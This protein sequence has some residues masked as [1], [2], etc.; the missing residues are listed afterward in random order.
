VRSVLGGIN[1]LKEDPGPLKAGVSSYIIST[2]EAD[3]NVIVK[4]MNVSVNCNCTAYLFC[5]LW[6]IGEKM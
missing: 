5:S 2:D 1:I 6:R 3:C 4:L